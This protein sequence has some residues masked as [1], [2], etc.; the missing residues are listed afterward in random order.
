MSEQEKTDR[1]ENKV[2]L[3]STWVFR[4]TMVV[5][6]WLAV[7]KVTDMEKIMDRLESRFEE[8]S[9][10]VNDIKVSSSVTQQR[11]NSIEKQLDTK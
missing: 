6:G 10:D 3:Y 1:A 8:V 5:A 9:K 11:V 7:E 2:D 4:I